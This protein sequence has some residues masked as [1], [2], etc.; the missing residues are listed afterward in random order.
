[1]GLLFG[2]DLIEDALAAKID[3][4]KVPGAVVLARSASKGE[5]TATFGTRSIGGDEPVT[6]EDHFRIGSNTKTMTAA[7]VLQLAQDGALDLDDPVSAYRPDVPNGHNITIAN[8]LEMRSGL[9]SYTLDEAFEARLDDEPGYAWR[10]A[11]LLGIAFACPPSFSP[12][13]KYEYSNT[14]TVLLGLI[15]EQLTE[16]SLEDAFRQRIFDPLGLTETTMPAVGDTSIPAPHPR[17]YMFGTNVTT[18]TEP[19]VPASQ[20]AEFEAGTLRP[21]D[22]TDSS[23]SWAWAAGSAISTAADAA[24]YVEALVDGELLGADQQRKWLASFRSTS[25]DPDSPLYGYH[26]GKFGP[27]IGHTGQ[28]PGFNS[29]IG[30]DPEQRNTLVVF[31]SLVNGP[32]GQMPVFEL[33]Q[34]IVAALYE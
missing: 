21:G 20:R 11:E 34:I 25:D 4:L 31:T 27:M 9:A 5:W 14:N 28:I 12:G 33:A 19:G 8:L 10:P 29:F 7:V 26:L 16:G 17:G 13:A 18:L 2:S 3:G 6:M 23:P 32:D 1:M 15:V 30:R 22:Y 24:R